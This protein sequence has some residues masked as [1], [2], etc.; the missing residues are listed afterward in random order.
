[1]FANATIHLHQHEKIPDNYSLIYSSHATAFDLQLSPFYM[2]PAVRPQTADAEYKLLNPHG[3]DCLIVIVPNVRHT[4]SILMR[5]LRNGQVAAILLVF[6]V[7]LLTN[8]LIKWKR[9]RNVFSHCFSAFAMC[10]AQNRVRVENRCEMLWTVGLLV[11]SVTSIATLSAVVYQKLL[12]VPISEP[13]RT[14]EDL[15][16]SDVTIY[17]AELLFELGP[18]FE[19]IE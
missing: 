8:I 12:V 2:R 1:M 13:I 16:K 9:S 6:A 19:M 11:F 7:F 5:L 14:M 17:V 10:L 3:F 15:A 4:T 18:W